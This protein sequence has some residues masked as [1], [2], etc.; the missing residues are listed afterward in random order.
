VL[1]N[2]VR[3]ALESGSPASEV[4]AV[5]SRAD[6]MVCI[7]VVD[8]GCGIADADAKRIFEPFFTTKSSGTGIG[9]V[10]SRRFVEAAGGSM[11]IASRE[12]GGASVHIRIPET[13][14]VQ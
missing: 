5:I 4:F 8:R 1:E 3:N 10:I 11:A 12:G 7:E 13:G 14:R 6:G 9:L 2:V